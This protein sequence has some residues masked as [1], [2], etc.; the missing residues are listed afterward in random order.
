M[1]W[2]RKVH[3]RIHNTPPPVPLHSQFDPE[4]AP[5]YHFL[6]ICFN[7]IFPYNLGI[8][9]D[10]FPSGLPTEIFHALRLS[11][12]SLLMIFF[13]EITLRISGKNQGRAKCC[14]VTALIFEVLRCVLLW[15]LYFFPLSHSNELDQSIGQG[16]MWSNVVFQSTDRS[17]ADQLLG[18]E[19]RIPSGAQI[20]ISY[21]Y[22]VLS[23]RG[24]CDG[25]IPRPE[26]CYPL[27]YVIVCD[28]EIP[29][30][31]WPW[32]TLGCCHRGKELCT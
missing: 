11:P 2:N 21:E 27:W 7:I 13:K 4:H 14:E 18:L 24:L 23:G 32:S 31:R 16:A 26:E 22:C 6:K 1:L 17:A 30:V 28:L 25:P 19:V 10:I 29:S 5:R 3:Y 15:R 12:I 20:S 8:A 9:T